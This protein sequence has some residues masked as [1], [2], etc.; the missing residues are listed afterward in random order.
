MALSPQR[1]KFAQGIASGLSQ[2]EAY[3]RAYPR[4]ENWKESALWPAA[5]RLVA[6][7]KVAARIDELKQELA[8]RALWTREDSVRTLC[9]IINRKATVDPDTG[10]EVYAPMDK[11]VIAAVKELNSM[12]GF[13]AAKKL[14]MSL[15][16]KTKEERDEIIRAARGDVD[17]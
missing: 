15:T 9:A 3:R 6:D 14:D 16:T 1:E 5:S 13:E 8:Q 11:D 2:A 10:A 12:H 4:S 17:G 7:S